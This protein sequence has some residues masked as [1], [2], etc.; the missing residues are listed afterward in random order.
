MNFMDMICNFQEEE[1]TQEQID[2]ARRQGER[3]GRLWALNQL[4]DNQR[5]ELRKREYLTY[6]RRNKAS[7]PP[8]QPTTPPPSTEKVVPPLPPPV[9]ELLPKP[10]P[11]DEIQLNIDIATMFGKLNMTVP[12]TEMCK[13]PSVR[14]EV[15][16]LLQVPTEKEYPPIILN[17]MYLDR[18]KDNNPPFY[19]SLGMNGLRLNNCM[20]DSG[21]STNVMSL[22]VMEQLGLKMTRPYGNVCGIDSKRVKVYGLCENVEVFLIDFPHINLLMNIVVIDV[23]DAWGMLLSRSWSAS[24]GGFLSMDLTHAHIP[25]GDGTFEVLYS[26]ERADKHVMD[27]NGPDYTSEDEFDEVP[28]TIE[29]DP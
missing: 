21:A 25:M 7:A 17:T 15:L 5:K 1:V 20:L 4:T 24:L 22:K 16:K 28:D 18:K 23:P 2:E 9:H 11:T 14:R 10:T 12:V 13:I 19:L 27:P 6:T 26:R 29:Y 8:S 3:E